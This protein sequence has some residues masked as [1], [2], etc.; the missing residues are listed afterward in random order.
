[1]VVVAAV[2]VVVVAIVVVVA[3]MVVVVVVVGVVVVVAGTVVFGA[4][5]VVVVGATKMRRPTA[6]RVVIFPMRHVPVTGQ[7]NTPVAPSAHKTAKPGEIDAVFFGQS[8]WVATETTRVRAAGSSEVLFQHSRGAGVAID[9]FSD[10]P[11]QVSRDSRRVTKPF[12]PMH[13]RTGATDLSNIV[14]A[15]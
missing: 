13:T 11:L 12:A 15:A 14:G 9:H 8:R 7:R 6:T 10:V 3:A 1:M 2:V 4:V 5:V